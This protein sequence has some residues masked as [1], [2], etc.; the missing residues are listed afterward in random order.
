[1]KT[2]K[3]ALEERGISFAHVARMNNISTQAVNQ[4]R[5]SP[6]LLSHSYI[7]ILKDIQEKEILNHSG[8]LLSNAAYELVRTFDL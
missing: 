2:L 6:V 4:Y 7:D 1:M 8:K 3:E 5:S